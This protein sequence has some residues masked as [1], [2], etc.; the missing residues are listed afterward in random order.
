MYGILINNSTYFAV[1]YDSIHESNF[2]HEA[3]TFAD[4][5]NTE[6]EMLNFASKEGIELN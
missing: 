4:G 5:F 3:A 1:A 6:T 2:G